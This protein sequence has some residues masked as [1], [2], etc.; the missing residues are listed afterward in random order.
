[1]SARWSGGDMSDVK[2]QLEKLR[3][4]TLDHAEYLRKGLNKPHDAR[5]M[6][7]ERIRKLIESRE[8]IYRNWRS[9]ADIIG[10]M[11]EV[12]K[13]EADEP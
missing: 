3:R 5:I 10:E 9:I 11:E 2:E 8:R 7:D 12:L 4:K 6:S 1:M 13:G